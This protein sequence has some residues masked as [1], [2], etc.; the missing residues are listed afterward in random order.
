M[1]LESCRKR[2]LSLGKSWKTTLSDVYYSISKVCCHTVQGTGINRGGLYI[3]DVQFY[4]AGEYRCVV[5]STTNEI[6]LVATLTV[7]GKYSI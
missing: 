6:T 1:A 2:T 5:K 3:T 7:I 4:H